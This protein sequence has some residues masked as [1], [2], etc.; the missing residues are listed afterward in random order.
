MIETI[1]NAI[2]AAILRAASAA[3]PDET[4]LGWHR[5]DNSTS[6]KFGSL[7][8]SPMPRACIAAIEAL[9]AQ[10]AGRIGDS[11]IDYDLHAAGLHMIP[12][13]GFLAQHVD[14][15]RH[16]LRPWKRTHSI[17]L[18]VNHQWAEDDGGMLRIEG[19]EIIPRHNTAV[20][21]ETPGVR[22]EVTEV[23][24]N[25]ARKT[26]ALF[27]WQESTDTGATA[28]TFGTR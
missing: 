7:P 23:R 19:H 4:W 6:R 12:P 25:V 1:H 22:H 13:G 3:W 21:F 27:A 5:Y 24:S 20:V 11:F 16:P 28:A 26:I 9:A 17:V 14:A 2:P 18:F 10:C 15:E 8:H